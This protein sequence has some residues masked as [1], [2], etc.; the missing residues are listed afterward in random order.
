MARTGATTK[1][2]V[3]PGSRKQTAAGSKPQDIRCGRLYLAAGARQITRD[4]Q[5]LHLSPK[6]YQLLL[7]FMRHCGEVL[8]RSFLVRE[9][10]NTNY[11]GDT[12]FLDVHI[13]WLRLKIEDDPSAPICLRTVRGVGYRFTPVPA[14]EAAPG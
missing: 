3:P 10:W 7:M 8:P 6:Q 9:I 13:R 12:R 4:G 11:M 2:T 5:P 1:D 14:E